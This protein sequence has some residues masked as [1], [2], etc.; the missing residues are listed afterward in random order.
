MTGHNFRVAAS[1]IIEYISGKQFDSF[2][3]ALDN[4]YSK[5]LEKRVQEK[6]ESS[7]VS[8]ASNNLRIQHF[9]VYK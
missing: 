2:N 7:T 5:E 1:F 4:L 6:S 8:E 3:E 9:P